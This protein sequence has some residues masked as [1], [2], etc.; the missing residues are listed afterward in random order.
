[1]FKKIILSVLLMLPLGVFAQEKIAY[2]SSQ[3]IIVIMPEYKQMQDSLQNTQKAIQAE[4]EI[5]KEEYNTKYQAF[6]KEGDTLIESIRIRRM[7]EI[8]DIEQRAST[9][10]EQ[11]Q[12]RLGQ[13]QQ[14][15]YEPILKKV[16]EA[17]QEVGKENNFTYILEGGSLLYISTTATDATPLVQKKLKL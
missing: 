14:A 13:L 17:I 11:E 12:Q 4:M 9:Y 8:Q 7:Q 2:F 6:M 3:E 1:M 5:L 15:L 16:R 10:A